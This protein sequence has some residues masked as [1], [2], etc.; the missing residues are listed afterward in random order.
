[1]L[2]GCESSSTACGITLAA[3]LAQPSICLCGETTRSQRTAGT[4]TGTEGEGTFGNERLHIIGG[5]W[6][7]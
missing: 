1:M 4:Q 3:S 6:F 7:L 5:I 2:S